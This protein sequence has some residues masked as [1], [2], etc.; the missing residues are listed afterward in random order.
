MLQFG[1]RIGEH[2]R[3]IVATTPRPIP[4]VRQILADPQTVVTRGSTADN[5]ANLAESFLKTIQER[6]AGTRL[7]RQ[8]LFAEILDDVPGGLWT[9]AMIDMA[10]EPVILP[11]MARVVVG[12]D[13]S[14]TRGRQ[15]RR[16]QHRDRSGG[17]GCGRTGICAGRPHL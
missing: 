10:R 7:G 5:A 3:Q 16:R 17:Q 11:D 6:Y 14:G 4:L 8:E 15:R 9:R 12:V 2:P 13:P 1:L